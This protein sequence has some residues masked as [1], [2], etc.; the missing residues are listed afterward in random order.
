M[1]K[2]DTRSFRNALGSFATGVAVVTARDHTN[3]PIGLTINSFT[4]VS[5]DPPF[6]LWSLN[7]SSS[8]LDSFRHCEHYAINILAA[9]QAPL[10]QRFAT[11][12]KNRMGDKFSGLDFCSGYSDAPLL[13][14]CCAWFECRNETQH[15]GGDHLIFIGRVERFHLAQRPPL[16]FHTG[17]YRTIQEV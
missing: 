14:D 17:Q 3:T 10:S 5:L 16:L 11:P 1:A 2:F 8:L 9:D 4:S 15:A 12:S 6:V 7:L 13:P